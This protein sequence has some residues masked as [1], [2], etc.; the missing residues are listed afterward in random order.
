MDPG[1]LRDALKSMDDPSVTGLLAWGTI[2]S[3]RTE[4]YFAAG[5]AAHL[6]DRTGTVMCT[7]GSVHLHTLDN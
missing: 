5:Q 3:G 1:V 7:D 4:D 6:R 2:H